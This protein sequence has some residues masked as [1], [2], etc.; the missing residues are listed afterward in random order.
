MWP[1]WGRSRKP[2]CGQ[3]AACRPRLGRRAVWQGRGHE[4]RDGGM[5]LGT[6]AETH[7]TPPDRGDRQQQRRERK[8][9]RE[10]NLS[11]SFNSAPYMFSSCYTPIWLRELEEWCIHVSRQSPDTRT[12]HGAARAATQGPLWW[13]WHVPK[14]P[15]PQ[16]ESH[17][18]AV[19]CKAQ[20]SAPPSWP[21]ADV[22]QK[23]QN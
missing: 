7:Q 3:S 14:T 5:N 13:I 12:C 17:L 22:D 18:L 11:F 16:Q 8:F 23:A 20:N 19:T 2:P 21:G 15:P 4:E 10:K 6:S 9:K 1:S